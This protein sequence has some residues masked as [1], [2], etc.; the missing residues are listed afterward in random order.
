MIDK[1]SISSTFKT[2]RVCSMFPDVPRCSQMFPDV[3]RCSQA[4][5]M[6]LLELA[7]LGN[8]D[9]LA[10]LLLSV[11]AGGKAPQRCGSLLKF[12]IF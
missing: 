7:T 6:T 1:V 9:D 4:G 5:G 10:S 8:S 11:G 2:L 12:E 3:P